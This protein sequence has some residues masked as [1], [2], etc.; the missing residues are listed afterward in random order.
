MSRLWK[1]A[2]WATDPAS[3]WDA[4]L[5]RLWAFYCALGYT[6]ILAIVF[7]LASVDL[8]VIRVAVTHRAIGTLLIATIGA[9]LYGV[10]VGA[11][12]WRVLRERVTI[13]RRSWVRASV[14]R[15]SS[16]GSSS[17]CRRTS[18]RTARAKT[19]ASLTS[20]AQPGARAWPGDRVRP[21]QGAAA[22]HHTMEVVDRRQ[23]RFL[24]DRRRRRQTVTA[25]G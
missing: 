1:L 18:R 25:R 21:G 16:S 17:S 11:L 22:L 12:Q 6:L 14:Y 4:R 13:P 24:A 10:V 19:S 9:V 20:C 7:G 3:G 5:W 15:R 23:P 2:A 8:D